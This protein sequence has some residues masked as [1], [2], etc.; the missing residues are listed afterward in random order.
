MP[1]AF[2]PH[3][4]LCSSYPLDFLLALQADVFC[5]DQ[6]PEGQACALPLRP[7]VYGGI[8]TNYVNHDIP[9]IMDPFLKGTVAIE[10]TL[11]D[12]SKTVLACVWTKI[13][14]DH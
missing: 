9:D 6:F 12:E 14:M 5:P 4:F 7:G 1:H 8:P 11:L 3:E 13:E 2:I 10:V